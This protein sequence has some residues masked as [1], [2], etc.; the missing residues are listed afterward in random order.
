L[1]MH[2]RSIRKKSDQGIKDSRGQVNDERETAI[3]ASVN[4]MT[5]EPLNPVFI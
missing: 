2:S 3:T 1:T 4:T 5:L